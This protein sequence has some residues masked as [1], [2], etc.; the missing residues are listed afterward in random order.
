MA[1]LLE[2][3]ELFRNVSDPDVEQ[4][5]RT[6]P[7]ETRWMV[8]DEKRR[9]A[10]MRE[11]EK[12]A[13]AESDIKPRNMLEE[14]QANTSSV[15]GGQPLGDIGQPD[16]AQYGGMDSSGGPDPYADQQGGVE[17]Y[18]LGGAVIPAI[19]ALGRTAAASSI[20]W[21][22]KL[23]Q[24][25]GAR[26]VPQAPGAAATAAQSAGRLPAGWTIGPHGVPMPPRGGVPG[27]AGRLSPPHPGDPVITT[28]F[29]QI[30]GRGVNLPQGRGAGVGRPAAS[31]AA[32][33][34]G[35][36]EAAEEAVKQGLIRRH[37]YI[38]GGAGLLA[39]NYMMGD[40]DEQASSLAGLGGT[41]A[42]TN[43]P[44]GTDQ[45]M[46]LL[47][48]VMD[49]DDELRERIGDSRISRKD[50]IRRVGL[51]AAEAMMT[52]PGGFGRGLG[53]AF[54][55]AGDELGAI[56]E[57]EGMMLRNAI[58][59]Y[60]VGSRSV[61]DLVGVISQINNSMN[62]G[63]RGGITKSMLIKIMNEE[64]MANIPEFLSRLAQAEAMVSGQGQVAQT[65]F[66]HSSIDSIYGAD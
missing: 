29:G 24:R 44:Q 27:P 39:A 12:A 3:Q 42:D 45:Y 20:P 40:D 60:Q 41:L 9:R 56:S 62:S 57:E 22:A 14:Y 63:G 32:A 15:L 30:P 46:E 8:M 64:G 2:L 33:T 38:A 11:A 35:A 53:A 37:P 36:T 48:R 34:G 43:A 61:V 66:D 55:A 1:T 25:L 13:L 4:L 7:K 31:P 52:T 65:D 58:S 26:A 16:Q 10:E 54:G 49:R 21:I 6:S 23:A 51:A 19:S 5:L 18:A 47:Q 59:E 50:K 28:P 17:E